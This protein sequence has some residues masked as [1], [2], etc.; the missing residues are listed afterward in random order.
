MTLSEVLTYI[1]PDSPLS[2]AEKL[3]DE[4]SI[5]HLLVVDSQNVLVGILTPHDLVMPWQHGESVRD[6]MTAWPIT[7]FPN[8]DLAQAADAF[9]FHQIGGLPRC[10]PRHRRWACYAQ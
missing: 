1:S 10:G 2:E 5:H 9:S 6:R 3:M 4:K 8:A 7:A